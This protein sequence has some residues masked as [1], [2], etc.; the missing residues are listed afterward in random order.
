MSRRVFLMTPQRI[1]SQRVQ[2][3][4]RGKKPCVQRAS[5]L[6]NRDSGDR[7]A[8]FLHGMPRIS[9][10]V[11]LLE[12]DTHGSQRERDRSFRR[13]ALRFL[14]AI[15]S[16]QHQRAHAKQRNGLRMRVGKGDESAIG[17]DCLSLFHCGRRVHE[18]HK[19]HAVNELLCHGFS[20]WGIVVCLFHHLNPAQRGWEIEMQDLTR[21]FARSARNGMLE[22]M[23]G[24]FEAKP[25]T[26]RDLA[27]LREEVVPKI[28]RLKE[29]VERIEE[30]MA[31]KEDLK[32]L[33]T[34]EDLKVNFNRLFELLK[35]P[36]G[37]SE[38]LERVEKRVGG[39]R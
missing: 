13:A 26:K 1:V 35:G 18:R 23:H 3:H 33:A 19:R 16:V 10:R 7:I 17:L 29:R 5:P 2:R 27:D 30:T 21:V 38:R 31:T 28:D 11:I 25:A 36:E 22:S 12:R 37:L 14:H 6:R 15:V 34:T 24:G 9:V 4:F 8:G 39:Y 20:V 32:K